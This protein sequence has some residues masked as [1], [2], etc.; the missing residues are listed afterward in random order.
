MALTLEQIQGEI[1]HSLVLFKPTTTLSGGLILQYDGDPNDISTPSTLGEELLYL[2]P[3][4]TFYSQ[5]DGTI[6][7]KQEDSPGG[8]WRTLGTPILIDSVTG[9]R[10]SLCLEGGNIT[11]HPLRSLS[12]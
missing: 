9:E 10:C 3:M 4:C 7:A 2:A 5:T 1:E 6:W 8:S 11:I 12:N